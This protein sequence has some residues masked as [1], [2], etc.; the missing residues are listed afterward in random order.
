MAELLLLLVFLALLVVA[1]YPVVRDALRRRR[2]SEPV[3]V[4]GLQLLLDGAQD[5][6]LSRLKEAV[7]ADTANIDAYVRLGDIYFARGDVERGLRIHE[8]LALR[9][10]LKPHEEVKVYRALARDYLRTDRKVKAISVLEEL[11]RADPRDVFSARELLGLYVETNSWDKA[12]ELLRN[13]ARESNQPRSVAALYA[14]FGRGR[15][16]SDAKAAQAALGEALRLD[17]N[18]LV[19]RACLG[20]MQLADGDAEAAVKT[21]TELLNAAPQQNALVR[22]RME[23]ALFELG[24]Y[25]D[26][27]ALYERLLRR[28][29]D[30]AGLVVALAGIYAKMER[31]DDAIRLLERA[32]RLPSAGPAVKLELAARYLARSDINRCRQLLEEVV[33]EMA[34]PGPTCV[35]CGHC[36]DTSL[37]RCS[38]CRT[39]QAAD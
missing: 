5:E 11:L 2:T 7:A 9:R 39:W 35:R 20:D 6:A 32:T 30:D 31:H 1:L 24:R 26:V 33:A 29:P 19:A 21:W 3:Y 38:E 22:G 8:N 16:G 14:E 13:V 17:R 37:L 18:C 12:Q 28:V 34:R 23:Q 15:M 25:E 27:T 4:E 36:L 10:N